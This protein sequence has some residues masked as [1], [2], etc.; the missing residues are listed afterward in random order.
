M[1]RD[2][3]LW[4][5]VLAGPIIWL[6]SFEANYALAPWACIFQAKLAL[7]IVSIVALA[8]AAASG[9]LAWRQWKQLGQEWPGDGG[10]AL[11]R[12]RIMAIGGVLLSAMFFLV[13]LAQAIP[14]VILGACQ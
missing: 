12:S 4:T 6:F 9:L 14:E 3:A 2:A 1:S 5:G 10:G 11:P 13:I 8:L 7:Y